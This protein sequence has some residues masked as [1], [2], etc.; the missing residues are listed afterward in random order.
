[1]KR[2]HRSVLQVAAA[3]RCGLMSSL[4]KG[5]LV[6]LLLTNAAG[7]G[8]VFPEVATPLRVVP[9]NREMTPP[10][11]ADLIY[12]EVAGA[13]I[14]NKTRDGRSLGENEDAAP[15]PFAIVFIGEDEL[16]RTPVES[17]SF[18]PTWELQPNGNYKIPTGKSVQIELVDS[19]S[20]SNQSICLKTL[21]DLHDEVAA[22]ESQLDLLCEGGSRILVTVGPARPRLGLGL[23]YE[24]VMGSINVTRL[25]SYSPAA[26]AG[27]KKGDSILEIM[28]KKVENLE[29]GEAQ[30]LINANAQIGVE[31][32]I[33][34]ENGQVKKIKIKEGAV[35]PLRKEFDQQQTLSE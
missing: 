19:N 3:A 15:D 10:P 30:S 34:H 11:P 16:F 35:Y 20:M 17:G 18:A 4:S 12:L 14:P 1:M 25:H 32:L 2:I 7:C 21:R 28:G 13:H 26:R 24:V 6:G 8:A 31:L 5:A 9:P 23:F 22:G 27:V 29:D 33:K